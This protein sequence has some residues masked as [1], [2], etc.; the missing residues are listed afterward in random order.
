LIFELRNVS[1]LH[2]L[3][4]GLQSDESS[5]TPT[6]LKIR[7]ANSTT[8]QTIN[9]KFSGFHVGLCSGCDFLGCDTVQVDSSISKEYTD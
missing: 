2:V 5:I 3:L 6:E 8:I 1:F 7:A 4:I 9:C